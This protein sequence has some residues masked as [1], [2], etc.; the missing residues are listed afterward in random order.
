MFDH[1]VSMG[2]TAA[3]S[4]RNVCEVLVPP[5]QL[6]SCQAHLLVFVLGRP[7]VAQPQERDTT[8]RSACA[9]RDEQDGEASRWVWPCC[10]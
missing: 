9:V 3:I 8:G 4:L 6:L 2:L 1:D 5:S 10:L 7:V